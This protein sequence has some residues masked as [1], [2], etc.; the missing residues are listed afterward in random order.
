MSRRH[1]LFAI[2]LLGGIFLAGDALLGLG[3]T[4]FFVHKAEVVSGVVTDARERPFEGWGEMLAHGNFP[5]EG[6][7][8]HRPIVRFSIDGHAAV[9]DRLPDLD[10]HAYPD[11]EQV[12]LLYHRPT[13]TTRIN[14]FHLLWGG[15]LIQLAGGCI[16][17]LLMRKLLRRKKHHRKDSS[18]SDASP[19]KPAK[20]EPPASSKRRRTSSEKKTAKATSGSGGQ[21]G[22]RPNQGS[23]KKNRMKRPEA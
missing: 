21:G 6:D 17:T 8:A 1:I 20:P 7:T 23:R 14:R 22:K 12:E 3:R 9:A 18:S 2:L 13:A 5:W 16:L 10:T 4:A 19:R 11:G 15:D